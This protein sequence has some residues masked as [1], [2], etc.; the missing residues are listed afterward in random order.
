MLILLENTVD[1]RYIGS[2]ACC[3]S[4][5]SCR[6]DDIWICPFCFGHRI[7]DCFQILDLLFACL[8]SLIGDLAG[9]SREHFQNFAQRAHISYLLDLFEQVFHIKRIF[10]EL[11]GNFHCLL[12]I[13]FILRLLNQGE[14]VAHAQNSRSHTIRMKYFQ[15]V[16]LFAH[17]DKLDRLSGNRSY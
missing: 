6:I 13:H 10:L 7:D 1:T 11:F 17:T 15:V 12:L 3:D 4:S 2:A 9:H 8:C 14:H 16:E 5:L